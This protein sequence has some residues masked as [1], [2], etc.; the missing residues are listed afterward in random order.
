ML[1][2]DSAMSAPV[3][4]VVLIAVAALLVFNSTWLI[5]TAVALGLLY[6]CY[7][8]IRSLV[9]AGG[10]TA[11]AATGPNVHA[12]ANPTGGDR[13]PERKEY[14]L[15]HWH[16]LARQSMRR[17]PAAMR[18]SELSGSMLLSAI[19]HALCLLCLSRRT[20]V[21]ERRRSDRPTWLSAARL[22]ARGPGTMGKFWEGNEGESI[23]RRFAMLV[24]GL[25]IGLISFVA[26]QY[27]TL[28]TLASADLARQVNSHDMPSGMY[29]ADGS[30]L[31]P[32]YLAYFGGMMV[33]LPWWKQ[34]DPLRRTRF[35]LMSTGWCVLW[36]WILNMFLPFPQPWG[37]LAA[38]ATI[39]GWL[40]CPLPWLSGE[41]RTVAI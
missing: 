12:R 6:L 37:V 40:R 25:G 13:P 33:L 30:P 21:E 22:L 11:G 17:K 2:A 41:Q 29:A 15:R 34:V 20:S 16:Q 9:L 10:G 8:G 39:S 38:A 27:L 31:L 36:A 1:A 18:A 14:R 3:K 28:E 7:F 5:P 35:S 4:V 32:A 26:S 23:R 19:G 24:A